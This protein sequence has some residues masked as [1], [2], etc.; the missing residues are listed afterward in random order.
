MYI[1]LIR[2]IEIVQPYLI[3]DYQ[4]AISLALFMIVQYFQFQIFSAIRVFINSVSLIHLPYFLGSLGRPGQQTLLSRA[5][6][7]YFDAPEIIEYIYTCFSMSMNNQIAPLYM[8]HLNIWEQLIDHPRILY[9]K[10]SRKLHGSSN[11][12]TRNKYDTDSL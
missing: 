11:F 1:K 2:S 5:K 6:F 10:F 3:L 4:I 7:Y 9:D 12:V 8:R